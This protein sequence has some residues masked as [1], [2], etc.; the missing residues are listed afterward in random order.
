MRGKYCTYLYKILQDTAANIEDKWLH[1]NA[2]K[3]NNGSKLCL[4]FTLAFG[5]DSNKDN[6]IMGLINAA[7]GRTIQQLQG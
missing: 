7:E 6:S 1:K 2:N 3:D 5:S 4:E